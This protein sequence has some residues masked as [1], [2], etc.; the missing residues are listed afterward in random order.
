MAFQDYSFSL[1]K[2]ILQVDQLEYR[3]KP[4]DRLQ[5]MK[6]GY[7]TLCSKQGMLTVVR[8]QAI[9][10]QHLNHTT[11]RADQELFDFGRKLYSL[12]KHTS[13]CTVQMLIFRTI[14]NF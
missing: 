9:M 1:S 8:D 7:L 4:S 14:Q 13:L 2:P 6:L 11:M 10:S 3:G 5:A 12:D